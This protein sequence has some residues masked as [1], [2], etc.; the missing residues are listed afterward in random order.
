MFKPFIAYGSN[1]TEHQ[2]YSPAWVF[3]PKIPGCFK[4]QIIKC[5]RA[6]ARFFE[7]GGGGGAARIWQSIASLI[8]GKH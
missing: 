8:S 4:P 5:C 7:R 1:A 2:K 6:V 3:P